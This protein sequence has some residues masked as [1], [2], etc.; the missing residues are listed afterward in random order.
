MEV[1]PV[2]SVG[3]VPR[4]RSDLLLEFNHSLNNQSGSSASL[5]DGEKSQIFFG[6]VNSL[7]VGGLQGG[8]LIGNQSG[9][10]L[11]NAEIEYLGANSDNFHE[12][13]IIIEFVA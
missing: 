6:S 3:G 9:Q 13:E 1:V 4:R 12:Y 11:Q 2:V 5:I 7:R 8:F 10:M